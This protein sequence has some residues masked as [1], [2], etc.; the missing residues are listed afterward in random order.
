MGIIDAANVTRSAL[1]NAA[2]IVALFLTT[3]VVIA[4]APEKKAAPAAAAVWVIWTSDV[5]QNPKRHRLLTSVRIQ[6]GTD[7]L[8]AVGLSA[9]RGEPAGCIWCCPLTR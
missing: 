4:D 9:Y 2:S 8:P 6:S 3:E 5:S 1:Q 7:S